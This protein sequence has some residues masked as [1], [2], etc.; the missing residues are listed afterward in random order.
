VCTV[1]FPVCFSNQSKKSNTQPGKPWF[2]LES[3]VIPAAGVIHQ[4]K[5]S[6]LKLQ[7]QVHKGEHTH[8]HTRAGADANTRVD[9]KPHFHLICSYIRLYTFKI[10]PHIHK[11]YYN[12]KIKSI[13]QQ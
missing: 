6:K 13:L 10:H 4:T 12:S 3:V 9:T 11:S 1:H 7:S 8:T 2:T 5:G